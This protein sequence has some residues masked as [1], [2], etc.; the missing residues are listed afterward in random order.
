[1]DRDGTKLGFD[2]E[3]LK[4]ANKI[5]DIPLIASGGVGTKEHFYEGA[6]VGQAEVLHRAGHLR[7][8][9]CRVVG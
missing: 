5:L 2:L 4:E 8:G 7:W 9:H 6:Q 1:M 3:L